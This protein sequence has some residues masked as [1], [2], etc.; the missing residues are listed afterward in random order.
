[1]EFFPLYPQ[2]VMSVSSKE[3]L[4]EPHLEAVIVASV[5]LGL[6]VLDRQGRFLYL[7]RL[8]ERF[9]EQTC[10]RSRNELLGKSFW[11][12]CP[13]VADSA[14]AKEYRQALAEERALELEAFYPALGRWFLFRAPPAE[15]VRCIYFQD[16][17]D[18]VRLERD[19]R[20]RREQLAAKQGQ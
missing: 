15:D 13:E 9:F 1:V 17:T 10:G 3:G 19:L 7:N 18:R 6:Y 11:E 14:F 16:V 12:Q 20:L 4:C 2:V 5:P 8:A